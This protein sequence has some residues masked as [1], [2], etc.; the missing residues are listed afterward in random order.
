[1]QGFF[2]TLFGTKH[3]LAVVL[4]SV[5]FTAIVLRSPMPGAA[6]LVLP[7][8]LLAGAAYLAKK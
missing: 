5:V 6:G 1:M 8:S 3:T 2:K 7:L 4:F